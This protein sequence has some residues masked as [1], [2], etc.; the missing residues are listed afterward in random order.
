[1]APV[2]YLLVLC[3]PM[4]HAA[5]PWRALSFNSSYLLVRASSSSGLPECLANDGCVTASRIADL[6]P[7]V[8]DGSTNATTTAAAACTGVD[9]PF[10]WCRRAAAA[11]YNCHDSR[12]VWTCAEENASWSLSHAACG[13]RV[14]HE[15]SFGSIADCDAALSV[16]FLPST[17]ADGACDMG[18][19]TARGASC[20]L[21][22]GTAGPTKPTRH[23]DDDASP[24]D[25][26][27]LVAGVVALAV[28]AGAVGCV[29]RSRKVARTQRRQRHLADTV[30][31]SCEIDD[32]N[33][34]S[35]FVRQL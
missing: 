12:T 23:D 2:G 4:V 17:A 20:L 16:L 33:V 9:E 27:L 14:V 22:N 6:L 18:A 5:S 32:N 31:S 28:F 24:A 8:V 11:L 35:V 10:D 19:I 7:L 3:L 15:A 34:S 13:S 1:M 30:C 25:R 21:L 26:L 29:W